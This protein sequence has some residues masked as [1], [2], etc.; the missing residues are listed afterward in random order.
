MT[1]LQQENATTTRLPKEL[2]DRL[3]KPFG[4]FL[5][6]EAGSGAVLLSFTV[7]AHAE[8]D[9]PLA[10]PF[11]NAWETPVGFQAG[12]WEFAFALRD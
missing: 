6:I 2:L 4:R 9:S 10:H 7:A 1:N 8:S 5:A 11:L 3:T 12:T